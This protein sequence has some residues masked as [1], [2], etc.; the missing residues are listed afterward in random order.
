MNKTDNIS[1][2]IQNCAFSLTTKFFTNIANIEVHQDRDFISKV[3]YADTQ[4]FT[5]ILF[6]ISKMTSLR[7]KRILS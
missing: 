2:F 1:F 7:S 6:S 4:F 3:K 5:K